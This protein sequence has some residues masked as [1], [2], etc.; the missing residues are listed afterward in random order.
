[1]CSLK[2]TNKNDQ[3]NN[4]VYLYENYKNTITRIIKKLQLLKLRIYFIFDSAQLV[5][6]QI[7]ANPIQEYTK[8]NLKKYN[9]N[10]KC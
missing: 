7:I 8:N 4:S 5:M 1:M 2:P 9:I 10:I 6:L 3:V